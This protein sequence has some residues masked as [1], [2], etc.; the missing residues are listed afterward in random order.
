MHNL[1]F[2]FA[3]LTLLHPSFAQDEA[4]LDITNKR[5]IPLTKAISYSVNQ[6][7]GSSDIAISYKPSCVTYGTI[8]LEFGDNDSSWIQ[9]PSELSTLMLSYVSPDFRPEYALNL[10]CKNWYGYWLERFKNCCIM[11]NDK[12]IKTVPPQFL[13]TAGGVFF[14][15]SMSS[16]PAMNGLLNKTKNLRYLGIRFQNMKPNFFGK[17][18]FETEKPLKNFFI[19]L[20]KLTN[21]QF[22]DIA[23]TQL[24]LFHYKIESFAFIPNLHLFNGAYNDIAPKGATYQNLFKKMTGIQ[25]ISIQGIKVLHHT[26]VENLLAHS[27]LKFMNLNGTKVKRGVVQELRKKAPSLVIY[28][29]PYLV[30]QQQQADQMAGVDDFLALN[31]NS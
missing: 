21:L 23:K 13:E 10:V 8:P 7:G 3:F 29:E 26:H 17:N 9:L 27:G 15:L 5:I 14:N 30:N 28:F 2:V 12:T 20:R 11:V 6:C 22:L 24:R 25:V 31:F 1:P 4:D 18:Q 16:F 19:A